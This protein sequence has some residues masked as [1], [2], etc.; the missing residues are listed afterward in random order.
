MPCR[1]NMCT[2]LSLVLLTVHCSDIAYN[3][4]QQ[5]PSSDCC[6][7]HRTSAWIYPSVDFYDSRNI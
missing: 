4:K 5:K 7:P 3:I 2:F 6:I 1:P